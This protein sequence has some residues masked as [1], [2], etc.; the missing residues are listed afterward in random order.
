[1]HGVTRV[2]ITDPDG[3]VA[4]PPSQHA[5]ITSSPRNCLFRWPRMLCPQVRYDI[6]ALQVQYPVRL[7]RFLEVRLTHLSLYESPSSRTHPVCEHFN[8]T[9]GGAC[10]LSPRWPLP[11]LFSASCNCSDVMPLTLAWTLREM[12]APVSCQPPAAEPPGHGAP[13]KP[14]LHVLARSAVRLA[15]CLLAGLLLCESS[16]RSCVLSDIVHLA[17]LFHGCSAYPI[18][19]AGQNLRGLS[20]QMTT[21]TAVPSHWIGSQIHKQIG[22]SST[23]PSTS[24]SEQPKE[25]TG[26][27]PVSRGL[28]FRCDVLPQG[29]E[30]SYSFYDAAEDF[31]MPC[32]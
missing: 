16:L 24:R 29:T 26:E 5:A 20:G 12:G 4:S 21:G 31:V 1:M 2:L 7:Q 17:S 14:K 6:T 8:E 22:T 13:P 23:E 18:A 30:C 19:S 11:G 9:A 15:T 32:E 27:L 28:T 3:H 10:A 25:R